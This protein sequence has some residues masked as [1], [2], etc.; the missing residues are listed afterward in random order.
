MAK[1]KVIIFDSPDPKAAYRAAVSASIFCGDHKLV[2]QF[3]TFSDC[4]SEN[5]N[6]FFGLPLSRDAYKPHEPIPEFF[7]YSPQAIY[8]MFEEFIISK[9]GKAFYGRV[10]ARRL[11]RDNVSGVYLIHENSYPESILAVANEVGIA[12]ILYI[13]ISSPNHQYDENDP[14]R[15]MRGYQNNPILNNIK[16]IEIPYVPDLALTRLLIHG[17]IKE[18][19]GVDDP[20]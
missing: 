15:D 9:F 11:H 8:D 7:G 13:G 19:L 6:R 20:L 2:P 12:N 10:M 16:R 3:A 1:P 17:N 18:F 5:V 14:K 4:I